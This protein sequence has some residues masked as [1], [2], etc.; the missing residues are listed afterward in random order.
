M[1]TDKY[2]NSTTKLFDCHYGND[3]NVFD[4][5]CLKGNE[6]V[7]IRDHRLVIVNEREIERLIIGCDCFVKVKRFVINGLNEL[8]SIIIGNWSFSLDDNNRIGS[9]C[10]IMNCDQL[11]EINIGVDS[12]NRYVSFKLK[13]LP[14]LISIQLDSHAFSNCQ[15]IVF[16]SKND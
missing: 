5:D 13:N 1:S 15:S 3:L 4:T 11:K 10:V 9:N 8:K 2:Y 7:F 16:E 14:S 6:R 12:F